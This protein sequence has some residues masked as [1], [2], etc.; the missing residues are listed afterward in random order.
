[1]S[2][3]KQIYLHEKLNGCGTDMQWYSFDQTGIIKLQVNLTAKANYFKTPESIMHKSDKIQTKSISRII[4]GSPNLLWMGNGSI[5]G[6]IMPTLAI[7]KELI[8]TE[9]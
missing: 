1:M 9:I 4:L 8:F 5:E 3:K 7:L 2:V 6:R